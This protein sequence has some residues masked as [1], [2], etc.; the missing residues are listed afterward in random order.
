MANA[1]WLDLLKFRVSY[2]MMGNDDIGNY[3]ARSYYTAQNLL[4]ISGLV[5]GNLGNESLMWERVSKANIV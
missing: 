5:K 2:G 4:G 1:N 3:T